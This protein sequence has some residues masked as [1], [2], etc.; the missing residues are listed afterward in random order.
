MAR[1]PARSVNDPLPLPDLAKPSAVCTKPSIRIG[2]VVV[3]SKRLTSPK[4][5]SQAELMSSRQVLVVEE[6]EHRTFI[7][8]VENR[9]QLVVDS[10]YVILALIVANIPAP[11]LPV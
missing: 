9:G 8:L 11:S 4:L 10:V 2:R 3:K 7:V 6:R 1:W 5:S